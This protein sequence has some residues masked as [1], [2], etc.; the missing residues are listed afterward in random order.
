MLIRRALEKDREGLKSLLDQVLMVH[1]AGRPDL[2]KP[3][4][5]KYGDD[6][7]L[8]IIHDDRSPVFVAVSD[9]GEVLGHA[10]CVL[11]EVSGVA[12]LVDRLTLY[13]DDI[14]VAEGARGRHV[15][16]AL[17]DHVI[18]FARE[19]GCYNVT[20]NVWSCNPGAQRF[21]EAMGMRPYK[22]AME[23]IL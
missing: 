1:Y 22:V 3:H 8:R 17:Y 15:G 5:R 9:E 14:Y 12:N 16:T 19:A 20:L 10:F 21:Y 4:T 18:A 7:L 13:I 23:A 11:E 2:F 6:E